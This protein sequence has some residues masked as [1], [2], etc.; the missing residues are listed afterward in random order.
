[1]VPLLALEYSGSNCQ[2]GETTVGTGADEYLMHPGAFDLF[3]PRGVV[4]GMW[5]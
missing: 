2:V 1:M 5:L 3:N 4:H